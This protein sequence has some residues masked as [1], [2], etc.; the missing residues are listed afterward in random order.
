[1]DRSHKTISF[2]IMEPR[3]G[4]FGPVGLF[5]IH[6]FLSLYRGRI[7]LLSKETKPKIVDNKL[8]QI[9]VMKKKLAFIM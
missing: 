5:I 1:M 2:K 8:C 7:D 6:A 3:V 9:L 4:K